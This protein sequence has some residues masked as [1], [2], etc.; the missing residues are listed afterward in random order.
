[1]RRPPP[2]GG[3]PQRQWL[4]SALRQYFATGRDRR[5]LIPAL[6]QAVAKNGLTAWKRTM[7]R[8]LVPVARLFADWDSG[9]RDP[10]ALF[11]THRPPDAIWRGHH[12]ALRRDLFYIHG[13]GY[14]VR[15]L[16]SDSRSLRERGTSMAITAVLASADADLGEDAV[17]VIEVWQLRKAQRRRYLRRDL[18]RN[19]GRLEHLLN[20]TAVRLQATP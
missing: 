3:N 12:L 11:L 17:E 20:D 9:E 6:E 8:S 13:N 18:D 7:S 4:D 14:M 2:E 10:H 19:Y 16:W 1:M 5:A 15:L